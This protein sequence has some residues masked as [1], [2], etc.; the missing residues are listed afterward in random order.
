M[1]ALAV[2]G[3]GLLWITP[4]VS[5]QAPGCFLFPASKLATGVVGV[6]YSQTLTAFSL[7]SIAPPYTYTM[8]FGTLPAGLT[9]STAGV[10]S[11]TPT[12]TGTTNFNVIVE[13]SEGNTDATI[14]ALTVS[15][16]APPTIS[17]TSPLPAGS[18]GTAYSETLAATGGS[19]PYTWSVTAGALPTGLTLSSG[20]VISGTPTASGS[21]SITVQVQD[22]AGGIASTSLS[23]TVSS[24]S[25]AL[26]IATASPLLSGY[27]GGTYSMTLAAAGGTP[28]Y[29]WSVTSG[30]LPAGL[31]LSSGG[32]ISGQ[33]SAAGGPVSVTIKVVDSNS[34]SATGNFALTVISVAGSISRVGVLSQFA[35]GGGY[36]TSIWV[37]NTSSAA[38]PVSL[39]F[40]A[41]DGTQVLKDANGNV[42]PTPLTVTQQGNVQSGIAATTLDRVLNPNTGLVIDGGQGQSDNVQGWVDVLST[43]SAV[44]GF[45]VFRYAPGGLTPGA[46]GFVT[47]WE[48]TVPLQTLLTTASMTLPF[49]NTSGFN[50][51]VAIGTLSNSAATIT[52]TFFD[53]NGNP[54]GTA[55][56]L[57]LAANGHTSFMLYAQYPFTAN[58]QGVAVFTGA[59]VMGLGL[60]A[61]PYGTLTSVPTILQ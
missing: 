61:S 53:I 4:P 54:L 58:K 16:T 18:T 55:Q 52:A 60:R 33:P 36:D 43:S 12:G 44:D 6:A 31:T 23:L 20:G 47:P 28:P 5:A 50:N 39:V 38:V 35:A 10:I 19:P 15:A 49:D 7:C 40:H 17:T 48:G 11:G 3:L 42:T 56:T 37:V 9:L 27:V 1:R 2:F 59:G 21:F 14:F 51:G 29:A 41:D 24:V 34:A 46:T 22:S 26:S 25:T 13:D 8:D 30:A 45:A 57:D 32:T